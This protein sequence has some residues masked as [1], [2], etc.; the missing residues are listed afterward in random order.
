VFNL[1]SCT[2]A[3]LTDLAV[4][5]H[6]NNSVHEQVEQNEHGGMECQLLT[7]T[8]VGGVAAQ[9]LLK[10]LTQPIHHIQCHLWPNY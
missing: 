1:V 9:N 6:S 4:S 3:V 2:H 5:S 10:L 7:L 8:Q